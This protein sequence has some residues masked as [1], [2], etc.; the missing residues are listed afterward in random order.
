MDGLNYRCAKISKPN[1]PSQTANQL[2][3]DL[4][5]YH[6]AI[7]RNGGPIAILKKK[8]AVVQMMK[9]RGE[10]GADDEMIQIYSGCLNQLVCTINLEDIKKFNKKWIA[11]YFTEQED[12]FLISEQREFI[13]FDA[14]TG[15]QK[16]KEVKGIDLKTINKLLVDSRYDQELDQLVLKN[17]I[18][19]FYLVE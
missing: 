7:A 16:F 5:N 2:P 8:E 9:E 6:V 3:A 11:F 10:G 1:T 13:A 12:L 15:M 4:E 14:K 17:K 19:E 18:G